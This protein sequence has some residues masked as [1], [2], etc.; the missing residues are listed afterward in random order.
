V[1]FDVLLLIQSML[2]SRCH[3]A[4]KQLEKGEKMPFITV[5]VSIWRGKGCTDLLTS[6]GRQFEA[7]VVGAG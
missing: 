2:Q 7:G 5:I 6:D 3:G 4:V 1:A